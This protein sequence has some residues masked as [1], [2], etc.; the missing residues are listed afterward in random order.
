MWGVSE[1]KS[2]SGLLI[3]KLRFAGGTDQA[4]GSG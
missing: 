3:E 4:A 2:F 1:R